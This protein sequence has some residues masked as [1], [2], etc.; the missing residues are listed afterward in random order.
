MD[1][2]ARNLQ[3]LTAVLAT[4][5]VAAGVWATKS[6]EQATPDAEAT[7]GRTIREQLEIIKSEIERRRS[8]V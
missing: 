2:S 6:N 1:A 3:L 7:G 5:T 8:E 4:L